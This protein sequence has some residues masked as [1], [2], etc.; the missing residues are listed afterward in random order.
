M[1]ITGDTAAAVYPE[2]DDFTPSPCLA[3][4][5]MNVVMDDDDDL[6][7]LPELDPIDSSLF[8]VDEEE[9]AILSDSEEEFGKFLLDAVDWL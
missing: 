5:S 1:K 4:N 9:L 3:E 2:Q 6:L 7:T 8:T